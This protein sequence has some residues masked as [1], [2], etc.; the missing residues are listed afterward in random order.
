MLLQ[1]DLDQDLLKKYL[2]AVTKTHKPFARIEFSGVELEDLQKNVKSWLEWTRSFTL[3]EVS[4]LLELVTSVKG[5]HIIREEALAVQVP[6]NWD[7]IWEDLSLPGVNFWS[8][9]FQ[10]LLTKRVKGI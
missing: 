1:L 4:R 10:P 5:I 8:E 3:S 7:S 2:P 6:E 9:F